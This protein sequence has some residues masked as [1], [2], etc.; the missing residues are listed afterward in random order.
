MYTSAS[1]FMD[2]A[3]DTHK[4]TIMIMITYILWNV[5]A[6]NTKSTQPPTK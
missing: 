1:I 2:S 4:V 6:N 3:S 5:F